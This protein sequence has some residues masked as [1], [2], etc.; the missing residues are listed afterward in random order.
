MKPLTSEWIRKAEGDFATAEREYLA[1]SPNYDAVAFHSQ[2]CAEKYLKARLVEVDIPFPKTHD[3]SVILDL[4][5]AVEPT[6]SELRSSL[7]ALTSLGIEVRYPG[8]FADKEDA[9][10]ALK[11]ARNVR[12]IVRVVLGQ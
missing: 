9:D 3:L 4:I 10:E 11:V 12:R 7:N 1:E 8:M 2:Q 5:L 6:W